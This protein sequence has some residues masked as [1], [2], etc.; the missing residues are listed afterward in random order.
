MRLIRSGLARSLVSG[1]IGFVGYGGW[2]FSA[3]LAYGLEAAVKAAL[4]QGSYSFALTLVITV[5][6]EYLYGLLAK[7]LLRFCV[8]FFGTCTVLYSTSWGVNFLAGTP[9]IFM[10]ILPGMII[11]TI[12][13]LGYTLSLRHLH[14][15]RQPGS[16]KPGTPHSGAIRS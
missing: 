7:P 9:E 2:A 4:T 13:T 16:I 14:T 5:L 3:N 8:T 1:A 15:G 11:G 6:M 10:T 12:Y